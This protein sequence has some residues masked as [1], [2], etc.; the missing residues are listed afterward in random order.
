MPV[1]QSEHLMGCLCAQKSAILVS[2]VWGEYMVGSGLHGMSRAVMSHA[3][4][5]SSFHNQSQELEVQELF[6]VNIPSV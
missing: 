6:L 1:W 5:K 2:C 3:A 4:Q